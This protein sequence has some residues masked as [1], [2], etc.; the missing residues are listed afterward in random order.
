MTPGPWLLSIC[1]RKDASAS[2]LDALNRCRQGTVGSNRCLHGTATQAHWVRS[3]PGDGVTLAVSISGA[4]DL[5]ASKECSAG[6][7]AAQ[8]H[9]LMASVKSGKAVDKGLRTDVSGVAFTDLALAAAH[10]GY[11][12]EPKGI[13]V[14]L[15]LIHI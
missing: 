1:N 13:D 4:R 8:K 10:V 9:G 6:A 14:F 2:F 12:I 11:I 7:D 5:A 15:S 3:G